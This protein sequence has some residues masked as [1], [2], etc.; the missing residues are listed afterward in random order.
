MN[1]K[2]NNNAAAS[3]HWWKPVLFAALAGGMA[4]GIRG[5]YGHET[6][7]MIA[8]LL[9]S[10]TLTFLLCPRVASLPVARAVAW[11][12]LAMGIGGSMTY[13]QTLGL[14]QDASLVGNWSALRWGMLGVAIKG[15]VWIGFC[16]L[17]LGM[18]LGGVRYRSKEILILFLAMLGAFFLGI[19]LLNS[20]FDP[21][22]KALPYLYFSDHWYWEP[23]VELKPRRECWGGLLLA[24]ATGIAYAGW[25]RKDCL[26]R[27]LAFWGILGGVLGF[28]GGQSLQAFHAWNPEIF[29]QGIWIEL[30]PHMNWWNMMET[31]YGAIMGA[32]LGLGLW[33]NRGRIHP[34]E[35][36]EE[37]RLRVGV[38]GI[39]LA[40]HLPLL[41]AV[42]FAEIGAIDR[43]YDLGLILVALPMVAVAGGRW[44]PF[45]Q[46]LPLTLL[47]IAG[48]T[49]VKQ[50]SYGEES[51]GM[52]ASW[53]IYFVVPL[54]LMTSFAIW[55]S[56]QGEKKQPGPLFLRRSLLACTWAYFLL[57]YAFFHFPWPWAEWTSRTPNGIIF[58][59]C[60]IGL[61]AMV[62]TSSTHSRQD[63]RL[64]KI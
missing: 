40:V 2:E 36:P 57:N 58:T 50:L 52:L 60:A 8:G 24:L 34:V 33:R 37:D 12:T 62:L 30:D 43:V 13:G 15:G 45:L 49:V 16:G 21:A 48:K 56:R 59:V 31:T 42:E 18:G 22:G 51:I 63:G 53:S 23:G 20:P 64:G 61:T 47:P 25:I 4:W 35:P 38:E 55:S 27:N 3:I 46:I 9:V 54:L 32:M 29:K 7:A 17:F 6:G 5:Q 19:S 44:W 28:P 39:L 11:G 1:D 10:L 26:A 41:I 14:T